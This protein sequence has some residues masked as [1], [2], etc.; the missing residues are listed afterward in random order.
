[1]TDD[2]EMTF[3]T[4]GEH[5]HQF[6]L[7]MPFVACK[8]HGGP[9]DDESYVAGWEMGALAERLGMMVLVGAIPQPV[10]TIHRANLEQLDLVVMP[11]GWHAVEITGEW[12][13]EWGLEEPMDP[14]VLVQIQPLTMSGPLADE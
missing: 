6:M 13:E 5:Q 2:N 9:Y 4:D 12:R 7:A 10:L 3:G 1:M 14:W 8:S 11:F